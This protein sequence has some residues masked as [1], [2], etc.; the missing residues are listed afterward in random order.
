MQREIG[1]LMVGMRPNVA[2]DNEARSTKA[3]HLCVSNL[4]A[5]S[6]ATWLRD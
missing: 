4:S 6:G 3:L 1:I 2:R 5:L